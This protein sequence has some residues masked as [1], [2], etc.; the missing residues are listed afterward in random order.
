MNLSNLRLFVIVPSLTKVHFIRINK[1]WMLIVTGGRKS[2]LGSIRDPRN[3]CL[4]QRLVGCH[5]TV[6]AHKAL[7]YL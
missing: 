6:N 1:K 5:L 3:D 2:N 4:S 7:L